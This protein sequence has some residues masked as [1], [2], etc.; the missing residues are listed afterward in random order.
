MLSLRGGNSVELTIRG[1]HAA[2]TTVTPAWHNALYNTKKRGFKMNNTRHAFRMRPIC[3]WTALAISAISSASFAQVAPDAKAQANG[4]ALS[5]V[6]ATTRIGVGIDDDRKVRGEIAQVFGETDTSSWVGE[7]YG[8]R[9]GL[10]LKLSYG[11]IDG[12]WR[13]GQSEKLAVTRIFGAIDQNR[14]DDRRLTLGVG[15]DWS[16]VFGS[17]YLARALSDRRN[18]GDVSRSLTETI[19][20]TD[21]DR[22]FT[23]DITTVTRTRTFARAYEWGVGARAGH[24]YEEGLLRLTAGLDFDFGKSSARQNTVSLM[25]EKYFHNSPFS[26]ALSVDSSRKSGGSDLDRSDTRA[27]VMFR[28]EIGSTSSGGTSSNFRPARQF[29]TVQVPRTIVETVTDPAPSTSATATAATAGNA[30]AAAASTT[31]QFKTETVQKTVTRELT[32]ME[33]FAFNS[34]VLGATQIA[35][36]KQFAQEAKTSTCPIKIDIT[37]HA[38]PY[39]N[40]RGNVIAANG[41]AK[42]VRDLLIKEGIPAEAISAVGMGGKNPLYPTKDARNRRAEVQLTG[43]VCSVVTEE[44]K[45]PVPVATQLQPQPTTRQVSRVVM[46]DKQE[47]VPVEPAWLRRALRTT[48][49]HKQTVDTYSVSEATTTR[50][51]GP[52]V[53]VNRCPMLVDDTATATSSGAT[54]INV[55]ANDTDADGNALTLQSVSTP[56]NGTAVVTGNRAVYTPRV[57]FSG[58]DSFTYTAT[59][60][61]AGCSR[62]ATVRVTVTA[63][64]APPVCNGDS[65]RVPAFGVS[66]GLNVLAN[67]TSAAPPLTLVSV[68]QPSLAGSS[69]TINRANNTI[70]YSPPGPFTVDTF[71]YTARDAA[72]GT[73]TGIVT[74]IDP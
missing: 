28:W 11:W 56:T 46:E 30:T 32:R 14:E 23:Q 5:Y 25:A 29:K 37:G 65:Y 34:A 17:V 12:D 18:A 6:G 16:N 51:E 39:G 45:T 53:L 35:S 62:T 54:T 2:K 55:L 20:G 3:H 22:P 50:T 60:G 38:C 26:V 9:S 43:G 41:R 52:R 64:V 73:C 42:N 57:G 47:E 58:A 74:L 48:P 66:R 69:V 4:G 36:L 71:T 70:D 49:T 63:P 31:P 44:V 61:N 10:G 8:S 13:K 19:T 21:G 68:T 67:D 24:F 27:L 15:R 7:A 59:D 40:E 72:G 1:W 33:N